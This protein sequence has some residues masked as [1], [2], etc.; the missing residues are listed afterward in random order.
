MIVIACLDDR[1]GMTFN[2]R[3]QSRDS[4]LCDRILNNTMGK[5]LY[6]NEYERAAVVGMESPAQTVAPEITWHTYLSVQ[7]SREPAVMA[8]A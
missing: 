8:R 3:R 6:M 7:T 5:A 4:V 1:G 2:F